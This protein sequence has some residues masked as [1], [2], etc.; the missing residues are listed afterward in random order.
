MGGLSTLKTL[1]EEA[2]RTA[3]TVSGLASQ[4]AGDLAKMSASLESAR[5][6]ARRTRE[7][8]EKE[9]DDAGARTADR[10]DDLRDRLRNA[11][12]QWAEEVKEALEAVEA[13]ALG[14]EDFLTTWGDAVVQVGDESRRV[15]ELLAGLD[16]GRRSEEIR[17]LI[18]DYRSGATDL[19]GVLELLTR[20]QFVVAQQLADAV[21]KLRDGKITLERLRELVERIQE[22]FPETEF[23]DLAEALLQGAREGRV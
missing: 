19:E 18:R 9:L 11:S 7:A 23:A 1:R 3:A 15:R 22:L 14:I 16:L 4:V 10:L 21:E 5:G 12:N 2:E 17:R 20:S 8:V 13:G 6:E